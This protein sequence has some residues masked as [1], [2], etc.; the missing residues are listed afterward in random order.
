MAT[1]IDSVSY[2]KSLF[3]KGVVALSANAAKICLKKAGIG[4]DRVGLLINTGVYNEYH[5]GEP[6]I[7]ALI[8]SK[9]IGNRNLLEAGTK[10]NDNLFSFDL[11][12]G[13]G[14]IMNAI[15]VIDGFLLSGDIEFGLVTAGD[16]KPRTGRTEGY[17][18][19]DGA[20]AILL[21][22]DKKNAGFTTFKTETYPE[23]I[24]D[25]KSSINWDDE[26]F[27]FRIEQQEDFMKHCV[28]S[29]GKAIYKF[30]EEENL[31]PDKIDLILTSQSPAGFAGEFKK[32]PHLG[33]KIIMNGKDHI[34]SSGLISNLHRVLYNAR[35]CKARNI[36]FVTV[37]AGITV[38]TSLYV[39]K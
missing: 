3:P 10:E 23:Y 38:T 29:A 28:E 21:A 36:L 16:V 5:T 15:Q 14:G 19:S 18:Y 33:E 12:N 30:L 17:N 6:A 24:S 37:G 34:Y 8:Q 26:K 11:H 9:I 20:G 7:A 35:F 2:V 32:L 1:I 22:G 27:C 4:F 31:E 39:N 25:H 13:G